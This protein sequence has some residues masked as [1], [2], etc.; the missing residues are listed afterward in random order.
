METVSISTLSQCAEQADGPALIPVGDASGTDRL[1][2]ITGNNDQQMQGSVWWPIEDKAGNKVDTAPHVANS[3]TEPLVDISQTQTVYSNFE[4]KNISNANYNVNEAFWLP[5]VESVLT[6]DVD[7]MESHP[8]NPE[9]KIPAVDSELVVPGLDLEFG[10]GLG[11]GGENGYNRPL[12]G[13]KI[14]WERFD[15]IWARF[16]L[17]PGQHVKV[18]IPY[19]LKESASLKLDGS[20]KTTTDVH[21]S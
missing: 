4:I 2:T 18:T 1:V 19:K 20:E 21:N 9:A 10:R 7:K 15:N 14:E 8:D 3:T 6:S 17:K 16:I 12:R 5:R 13:N 11:L